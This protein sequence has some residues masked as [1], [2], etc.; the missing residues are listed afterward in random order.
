MSARPRNRCAAAV[1]W[2]LCAGAVAPLQAAPVTFDLPGQPLGDALVAIANQTDTNILVDK[3]LVA[4]IAAPTLKAEL[5][6]GAALDVLL[7]GTGLKHRFINEHTVLIEAAATPVQSGAADSSSALIDEVVVRGTFEML[8]FGKEAQTLRNIPQS[9][10]IMTRER[11]DEQNIVTVEQALNRTVGVFA[12]DQGN[13]GGAVNVFSRG[14]YMGAQYDGVPGSLAMNLGNSQFDLAIYERVEVLRGPAGLLQGAGDAGGAVNLVRKRPQN[15]FAGAVNVSYGSW[16]NL[17]AD[18]DVGGPLNAS[19][20]VRARGVVVRED[21]EFFYDHADKESLTGYGIVEFDLTPATRLGISVGVQNTDLVPYMGLPLAVDSNGRYSLLDVKRSTYTNVDW[22]RT[23]RDVKQG[24][25]DLEHR[26]ANDW[27]VKLY[28]HRRD[29]L[30]REVNGY[31][32]GAVSLSTYQVPYLTTAQRYEFE[33]TGVDIN[34]S[35]PVELFGRRHEL[36]FGF[37]FDGY[38]NWTSPNAGFYPNRNLF[39]PGLDASLAPTTPNTLSQR[40][41]QRGLYGM[42]RI[43]LLEP[44]TLII[45]GRIGD[46]TQDARDLAPTATPAPWVEALSA[47]NEFTPYGGLVWDIT[48]QLSWYSSYT[49]IFS[50]QSQFDFRGSVLDPRIG[51]Q[52]ETGLKGEHFNGRLTTSLALFRL[53][54]SNRALMDPN[55]GGCTFNPDGACYVASGVIESEGWELEIV[56]RPLPGWDVSA[57]YTDFKQEDRATGLPQQRWV[58]KRVFKLWSNYTFDGDVWGG[59]LQGWNIGAGL[60]AQNRTYIDFLS[61]P[62]PFIELPG[63]TVV[64]LQVGYR[65]NPQ[66]QTTLSVNNV[67]D[68][69]YYSSIYS[70]FL[71]RYGEPR[72][73]MLSVRAKF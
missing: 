13:G 50:P 43:K 1:A 23:E 34:V 6:L 14:Q 53:R 66:L 3:K 29:V 44:L 12:H 52:I 26:F 72:N 70:F 36:L 62:T 73:V 20:S 47:D 41:E 18:L 37:T 49:E 42:A 5:E 24:V 7:K 32:I 4:G 35:G 19:G 9:V 30:T 64:D 17:H 55:H 11:L 39:A 65:I 46:Y 59:I 67:A 33:S 40:V 25:F 38:E 58:P 8:S 56:G 15:E 27:K 48:E 54:D 61:P 60:H 28:A 21:R 16:N 57:G 2:I 68:R 31:P 51:Y 63:Y 22:A 45:G 69:D 71:N 10:S